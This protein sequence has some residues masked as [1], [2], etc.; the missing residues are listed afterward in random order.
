MLSEGSR[1]TIRDIV[2]QSLKAALAGDVYHP[3]E[4]QAPELHAKC[5][6]FVTLKTDGQLRG[7]IGCFESNEPLYFTVARIT[8]QSALEDAR[9]FGNQL[10]RADLPRVHFDVS[11]LSPLEPCGD[12]ESIELGKH[13]IYVKSGLRRGC[14][15][16][17]VAEEAGW[18]VEEFWSY[19]CSHKAGL[20][21]DA[22]KTGEAELLTFTAEIV[23]G[24]ME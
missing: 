1:E 11:V 13:G 14:F 7:C 18:G 3:P 20:A 21:P 22:W 12:P 17:Q 8:R 2:R 9:F 4:P 19:C 16:P 24:G 10:T 23:E 5:G 15:L 6:C